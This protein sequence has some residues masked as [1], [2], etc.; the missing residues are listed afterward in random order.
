MHYRDHTFPTGC[1]PAPVPRQSH[2]LDIRRTETMHE[3]HK[4]KVC[5]LIL[6]R[7]SRVRSYPC[8]SKS[9]HRSSPL[10]IAIKCGYHTISFLQTFQILH[11]TAP[12]YLQTIFSINENMRKI[13]DRLER[14]EVC[15]CESEYI[16]KSCKMLIMFGKSKLI[17]LLINCRHCL[18][19]DMGGG[20]II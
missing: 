7:M 1:L 20:S 11:E 4:Q 16:H 6:H 18:S 19:I 12:K 5:I 17:F 15:V 8:V 13:Y 9:A 3:Y 2:I 10:I 14:N